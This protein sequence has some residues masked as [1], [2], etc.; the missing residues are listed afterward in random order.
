MQQIALRDDI[1][2]GPDAEDNE[3]MESLA[4]AEKSLGVKMKTPNKIPQ[5][6]W[7]PAKYDVEE[8]Q[9]GQ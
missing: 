8:V 4:S 5:E 6:G 9:I 1:M 3:I 7:H 2:D